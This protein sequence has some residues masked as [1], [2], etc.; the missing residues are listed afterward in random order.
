M[1]T[2]IINKE[3]KTASIEGRV[4]PRFG[5]YELYQGTVYYQRYANPDLFT[6][7]FAGSSEWFIPPDE[8]TK[9]QK[10]YTHALNS[11]GQLVL[12]LKPAQNQDIMDIHNDNLY[13]NRDN[14][15]MFCHTFRNEA[16]TDQ[17][18]LESLKN[19]Y[20]LDVIHWIYQNYSQLQSRIA[21]ENINAVRSMVR[22]ISATMAA[23]FITYN[24]TSNIH[25]LHPNYTTISKLEMTRGKLKGRLEH[26]K[27]L[28]E[29]KLKWDMTPEQFMTAFMTPPPATILLYIDS[30]N[31]RGGT[32]ATAE[33]TVVNTRPNAGTIKW[34][35]KL[36]SIWSDIPDA[37]G[38]S[39]TP[40][41]T[42]DLI[43]RAVAT[44]YLDL[45]GETIP[46]VV[47]NELSIQR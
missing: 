28:D 6:L 24:E 25:A 44:G 12:T 42:Q 45:D 9:N 33:L 22:K 4:L 15:R 27:T 3:D 46:D 36:G 47:S 14:W 26:D 39:Y 34:Q 30:I 29:P 18:R 21:F 2:I 41:T 23:Q 1:T 10:H 32:P 11:Q 5:V 35:Q 37:T 8:I 31:N 17:H 43:I 38:T 13:V 40:P 16:E 20:Q 7:G 19:C